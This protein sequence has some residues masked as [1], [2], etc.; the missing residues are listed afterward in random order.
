MLAREMT[1]RILLLSSVFLLASVYI[2]KAA[3]PE[4]IPLK[5]PLAGVP[6]EIDKW[7]GQDTPDLDARAIAILA[8]DDYLNR[9]YAA[10]NELVGL[11][12]GFYGTQR[13]GASIHS[14]LNCLPG[15]GWIP[16]ERT[17][18]SIPVSASEASV[19]T[20]DIKV[21]QILI[22]KGS[23]RQVV[24]Y[25]YQ[26]HGRVLANEYWGKFYMVLDAMRLNRTDGALV[27]VT[28]PVSISETTAQQAAITFV[29][30]LFPLLSR[31]LP[32]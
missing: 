16:V 15:A 5:R 10:D 23:S 30:T 6:L 31:Y 11:Y 7:M 2:T 26:S 21:N 18:V 22:E 9:V 25:W 24:L 4:I 27:R 29:Q 14:P 8:A 19:P 12:V 13:Q 3:R 32:A 1:G 20:Q 17:L 28:S